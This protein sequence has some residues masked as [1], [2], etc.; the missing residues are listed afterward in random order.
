MGI[1]ASN[2]WLGETNREWGRPSAMDEA[3]KQ[4]ADLLCALERT[5]AS[6]GAMAEPDVISAQGNGSLTASLAAARIAASGVRTI[7]CPCV[8]CISFS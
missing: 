4:R 6:G 2:Q 7:L 3:V 8:A 1:D 5:A